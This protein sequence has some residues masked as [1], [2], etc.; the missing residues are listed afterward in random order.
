MLLNATAAIARWSLWLMLSAWLGV[1]AMWASLHWVIVPRI[2]EIRP[3]LETRASRIMGMPVKVGSVAAFTNGVIP[4][5]EFK[6]VRLLDPAGREALKLPRVLV[7]LS[8]K[9]LLG[10]G[11][12]QVYID[13]A[14][15]DVRR[16]ASG[17]ILVGG[18]DFSPNGQEDGTLED[19][20]FSQSELA[21]RNG[22]VTW[23][24]EMRGLPA[25][26]LRQ[27]DG[28]LRN[29]YHKHDFRLDAT[30]P[31]EFGGRFGVMAQFKQPLLSLRNGQWREWDGQLYAAFASVDVALLKRYLP[32]QMEVS[33]G[34][35]AL[36]VWAGVE[37]GKLSNASADLALS[38]VNARLE[39]SLSPLE[40]TSVTGRLGLR[41]LAQGFEFSTQN[42]QFR[43]QDGLHWPG[44][45][46]RVTFSAAGQ[47]GPLARGELEADALDLQALSQIA[48]RV[49]LEEGI[50]AALARWAPRGQVQT[51]KASWQGLPGQGGKYSAKGKLVDLALAAVA[52]PVADPK[53]AGLMPAHTAGAPG[54]HGVGVDFEL[55]E[56]GGRASLVVQKGAIELPGVFDDPVITLDQATTD[57][58]WKIDGLRMSVQ[59]PNL[60]FS[61]MDAQG[62]AQVKWHTADGKAVA[63]FPG[64]LDLQGNLS[65]MQ[66]TSV[67]RYLP[68][69][70]LPQVRQY[71]RD[72]VQKGTASGVKFKV[73]GDLRDMPFID[74]KLGEFRI[75][76]NMSDATFAYVPRSFLPVDSMPWPEFTHVSGELVID[77][78]SLQINGAKGRVAMPPGQGSAGGLQITKGEGQIADLLHS[79]TVRVNAEARGLASD[80]LL[81]VNNSPLSEMTQH[82]LAKTTATGN[83]DL[84]LR[85]NL[86]LGQLAKTTLQGSIALVGSDIQIAPQTPVLAR[87]RGLVNFNEAGFSLNGLQARVLGG[88]ARIDGGTQAPALGGVLPGTGAL[89][90]P[91]MASVGSTSR[92]QPG[93]V[94]RAQ[95]SVSAD[96]L[97]QAKDLGLLSR[98]AQYASG[99]T[100]Y[101][102]VLAFRAAGPEVL[103]TSNLTGLALN[104]PAPLGKPG[105]SPLALRFETNF[106][107][108][109]P[110]HS[111][112]KALSPSVP[113]QLE[114]MQLDVGRLARVT[115]VR[116]VSGPVGRVLRGSI[117]VGLS[118]E[119]TVLL[120]EAGV[121][122]N[123]NADSLDLDAWS[124]ALTNATGVRL[125][126]PDGTAQSA[127]N[128]NANAGT[129]AVQAYLPSVLALR[130]RE[131][132][133]GGRKLGNVVVG[134]RREGPNWHANVHAKELNGYIEYRQGGGN[135]AG[136][137]YARLANLSLEQSAQKDVEKL[138][139]EQP[140]SIP[141]LD[142]M[143]DDFELRGK[144]LGRLE[145]E[146]LN[147]RL[148]GSASSGGAADDGPREWRLSKF[149]IAMPEATFAASGNWARLNAQ[150]QNPGTSP[151][152]N[153]TNLADRR[154]TVMNFKL[155]IND[156]GDLLNRFG[157]KDVIRKGKGKL[158][159]QVGWAGSPLTPDYRTM[160]GAF[161]LDVE[162]G[163]FLKADP[164]IA[165][166]FGV[167]SLQSLPR[168]LALDFRD[169]FSE[170]FAF[171]FV[172]GD[173][174]IDMG[175]AS[176]NNL[177]MKGVNAAVLMDGRADIEHE[178]Q[179]LRVI[180]VP[181]INAGTASLIAT[182]IN[183]VV[184]LGTFLAQ[185]LLRRP[186]IESSTQEFHVDGTWIDPKVTRVARSGAAQADKPEATK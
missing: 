88:D 85:L 27:V 76:G 70:M 128:A 16:L 124:A 31:A 91:Q 36:R 111:S 75:S 180:V 169:V 166:L 110:T 117:A 175:I 135:G 123:I 8:P 171:D 154:R 54:F 66:G 98:L 176:T 14:E 40:L 77:R 174:K 21:L 26:T 179:D 141:A 178:T 5:L 18:I 15:L 55:T 35:G 102:A 6:D 118:A 137:V 122:A 22:A 184:G 64:V 101:L 82:I 113:P 39:S 94:L 53:P 19:W 170:G 149:N 74:P 160:A 162:A 108:A 12:E 46:A 62:D 33:N 29:P 150:G 49:P 30:P 78:T 182:V 148:P 23:T 186:L 130:V 13:G 48:N 145:I 52:D 106:L 133:A 138:L 157:M 156:A 89:P 103:V 4:S 140:T 45:N 56:T 2:D 144:R 142:I 181:E 58:V 11:F 72:A 63:R 173:V 120:P 67:H 119:E 146:A 73:K 68:R 129:S 37:R 168:R 17:Q 152:G 114:R 132:V 167:L 172:R 90:A 7:A 24:D 59:L 112:D 164:G 104:L 61:N 121:A 115:Y 10:F 47:A 96:A 147:R 69:I 28:V 32:G 163:Q 80:A 50:H 51:I 131:L 143:V 65:R 165:K 183:P 125:V 60:K 83:V 95:G 92:S 158:E 177:Q 161:T 134:G 87:T 86:P 155:D 57:V 79:P 81:A 153:G 127:A 38:N 185:L 44:G 43:T 93:I 42:L 41:S 97:K 105:P 99:N 84:K 109:A 9:S 116:D 71:L 136:R 3:W 159:G 1:A 139:D 100:D 107:A 34:L 126:P 151:A 25:L 20:L